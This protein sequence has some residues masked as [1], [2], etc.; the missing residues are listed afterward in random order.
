MIDRFGLLPEP[1]KALF[2][3]TAFKLKAESL[4]I[5]KVNAGESGGR[6][7]FDQET[8]VDPGSIVE[9][10]QSEPHRY[11]LTSA[12]QLSFSDKMETAESRF[13][14]VERLLQ[15]L[16]AKRVSATG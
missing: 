16:D 4:G 3:V 15:R 13:N 9:L 11:K 10:V 14:K 6:I 12:N 2:R 8:V 7:E 1:V 5:K